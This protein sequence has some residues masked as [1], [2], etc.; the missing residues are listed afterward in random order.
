MHCFRPSAFP[1]LLLIASC[2]ESTAP[3]PGG[4]GAIDVRVRVEPTTVAPG[5]TAN[6][7]L[8]LRNTSTG[9]VTIS[10]CP[11]YYWVETH[12][13][14][15]DR[16]L[17]DGQIVGGSKTVACL[18]ASLVYIPLTFAPFETK[19]LTFNWL[20]GSAQEVPRG[21]YDVFGWVSDPAHAS[22][23]AQITVLPAN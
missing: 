6:V 16:A 3:N 5:T 4:L 10:A 2:T 14:L 19:T 7:I 15:I 13:T 11:I 12:Q 22:G 1:I 20:V 17:G 8:T 21:V 18:A 9:P 23:A